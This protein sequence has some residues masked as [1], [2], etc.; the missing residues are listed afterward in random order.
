MWN[1]VHN[2]ELS[3]NKANC[4]TPTRVTLCTHRPA[5]LIVR[6]M[7]AI[8]PTAAEKRTS[9][10]VGFMPIETISAKKKDRLA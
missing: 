3:P 1:Y 2:W 8:R 5:C 6:S 4:S 9:F 10:E 7:S